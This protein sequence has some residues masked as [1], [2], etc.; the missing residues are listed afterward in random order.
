MINIRFMTVLVRIA[1]IYNASAV[2]VFLT[3]GA[4]QFLGV[5][6]PYS[7]FWVW[8]PALLGLF[9]GLVLFFSAKDLVKYG[10]FPYWN[11]IIRLTFVISTFVLDFPGSTG[12]FVKL[13]AFGDVPLGLLCVFGIPK[14]TQRTQGELITNR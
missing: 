12:V 1:G 2:L 6:L 3:P 5:D 8:L 11:G 4:L 14:A 9:V 13:L 7:P 10:V